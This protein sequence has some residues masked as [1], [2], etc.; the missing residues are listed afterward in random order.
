MSLFIDMSADDP[1]W[2]ALANPTRRALLD[3]L[4]AGPQTTGDLL[5]LFPALCR[6]A[7]MKHLDILAAAELVLV[8]RQGRK[9]WNHLNPMPLQS[10]YERWVAPHVRGTAAALSRLRQHTETKERR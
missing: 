4:A 10:I 6:T 2:K 1:I 3:A 5:T 7:V 8:R 9:R